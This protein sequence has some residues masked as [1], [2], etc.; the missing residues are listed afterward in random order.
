MQAHTYPVCLQSDEG[1]VNVAKS[2]FRSLKA[3]YFDSNRVCYVSATVRFV[4]RGFCLR[5]DPE[6]LKLCAGILLTS[7]ALRCD[8]EMVRAKRKLIKAYSNIRC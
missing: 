4:N 3:F 7:W 6:E 1:F 8:R 5:D 2:Q